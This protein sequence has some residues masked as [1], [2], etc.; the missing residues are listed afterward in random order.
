MS[1]FKS[2]KTNFEGLR[3]GRTNVA[4]TYGSSVVED[5]ASDSFRRE[6]RSRAS[7]SCQL[8]LDDTGESQDS[9]SYGRPKRE[10]GGYD[11]LRQGGGINKIKN[12]R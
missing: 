3:N 2:Q 7:R 11:D 8:R 1:G 4:A 12:R 5:A 6:R 9:E 10:H